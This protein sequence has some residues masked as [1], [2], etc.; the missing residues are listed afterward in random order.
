MDFLFSVN[1]KN[2]V[3]ISEIFEPRHEKTCPGFPTRVESNGSVQPQKLG[4]GLK[5]RL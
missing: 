4:R 1:N 2:I 5:F 3:S